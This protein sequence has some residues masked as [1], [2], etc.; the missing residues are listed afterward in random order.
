[1]TGPTGTDPQDGRASTPEL[2]TTLLVLIAAAIVVIAGGAV[3]IALG[4]QH[5]SGMPMASV[6]TP[7]D[8]SADVPMAFT[9]ADVPADV[10]S[11]YHM[12]HDMPAPYRA[13]PCFCGCQAT[14]DHRNLH[15]CFVTPDG[16]WE[17]HASGCAVCIQESQMVQRMLAKQLPYDVMHDRIVQAFG[18]L[19]GAAQS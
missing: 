7:S 18:A 16:R 6:A 11:H 8:A 4:V 10:A 3:G 9:L 2:L 12:A 19:T 17:V 5:G 14:L 13:V 1:V 15:D